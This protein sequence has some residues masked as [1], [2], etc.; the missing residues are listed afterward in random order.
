[1]S[2]MNWQHFCSEVDIDKGIFEPLEVRIFEIYLTFDVF[3]VT[4]VTPFL[5][6]LGASQVLSDKER[7]LISTGRRSNYT[8]L[9]SELYC[10][11]TVY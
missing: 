6:V 2:R 4:Y 3:H 8:E 11:L 7:F 5:R 9:Y 10:V 1:M